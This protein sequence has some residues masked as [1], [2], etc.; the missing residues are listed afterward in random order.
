MNTDI[1]YLVSNE[2]LKKAHI[3]ISTI[4][5]N[6]FLIIL[7]W[8]NFK[9]DLKRYLSTKN[10]AKVYSFLIKYFSFSPLKY[11]FFYFNILLFL[12]QDVISGHPKM[13]NVIVPTYNLLQVY[14]L[15]NNKKINMLFFII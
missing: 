5:D 9:P 8:I 1:I 12:R 11:S 4:M 7:F 14:F 2:K 3:I 15:L 6:S 13:G 10:I